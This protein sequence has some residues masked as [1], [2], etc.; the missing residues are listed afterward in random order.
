MV[1][2]L[3]W[4]AL[5]AAVVLAGCATPSLDAKVKSQIKT[6]VIEPINLS[7]P[8][9]ATPGSST[10]AVISGNMGSNNGDE[11]A[12]YHALV[13]RHVDM[14][15]VINQTARRELQERGF[16]VVEPGQLS[17]ARLKIQGAYALGL[18]S[19]P[20]DPRRRVS[21]VLY[22]TLVG[23][24][25]RNLWGSQAFGF[26][27]DEVYKAK[28]KFA[29]YDEWFKNEALLAEQHKLSAEMVTVELLKGL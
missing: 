29:L 27:S 21:T 28:V 3:R 22:V 5:T 25:G 23:A 10:A 18:A 14:A 6:V 4:A 11:R 20:G 1:K 17:D 13:K 2:Y 15:G 26:K 7:E 12:A 9:V 19:L 8:G 24:D 16:R